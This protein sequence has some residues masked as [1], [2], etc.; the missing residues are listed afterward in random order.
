M[1]LKEILCEDVDWI[2]LAQDK[3]HWWD[4]VNIVTNIM[5]P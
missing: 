4:P 3:E 1:D 5:F 2:K